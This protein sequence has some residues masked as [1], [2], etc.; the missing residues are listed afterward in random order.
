MSP[1]STI[2]RANI[3]DDLRLREWSAPGNDVA[4]GL[5]AMLWAQ[6]VSAWT[7]F[8]TV[9][10]DL[11]K[12]VA[13]TPTHDPMRI[14]NKSI[15][16]G[17]TYKLQEFKKS[18][19]FSS[20][21]AIRAAYSASFFDPAQPEKSDFL[22][23]ILGSDKLDAVAAV[24]NLIVHNAGTADSIYLEIQKLIPTLLTNPTD[25]ILTIT[26]QEASRLVGEAIIGGSR[27]MAAVDKWT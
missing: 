12:G 25:G 3:R 18:P 22:D 17:R 7:I 21:A 11:W 5:E 10:E 20:L 14:S 9:A 16:R 1:N 26:A 23:S 27:L 13:P 19:K 4:K 6:I 24:R 2:R 8:E 15:R